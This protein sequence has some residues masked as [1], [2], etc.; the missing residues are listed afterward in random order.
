[1]TAKELILTMVADE[2]SITPVTNTIWHSDDAAATRVS[3]RT[4]KY[5][6]I[7]DCDVDYALMTHDG[8]RDHLH[9]FL[10]GEDDE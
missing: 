4:G 3:I 10:M 6:E 2:I 1:M 7:L 9:I 5:H 8:G